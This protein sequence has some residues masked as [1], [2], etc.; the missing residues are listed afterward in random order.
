MYNCPD[1][2]FMPKSIQN[3]CAVL[4]TSIFS[5][6]ASYQLARLEIKVVTAV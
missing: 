4:S 5:Q 2:M 3:Q 6:R 1:A